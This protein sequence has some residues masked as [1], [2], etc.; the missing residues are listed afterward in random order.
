M[1]LAWIERAELL[2][3]AAAFICGIISATSLTVGQGEFG[4]QCILYGTASYNDTGKAFYISGF[5]SF[6]LCYFVSAISVLIAL[7]CFSI[8]LYWVYASCVDD[9]KRGSI[10]LNISLVVSSL[11]LFFL[12]VSACILRVGMDALCDSIL[13]TKQVESCP[14]AESEPWEAPADGSRF[15]ANLHNAEASAWANWVF[16]II[17]LVLLIIQ[18]RRESSSGSSTFRPLAAS[19]PEWATGETDAIFGSR[20]QRP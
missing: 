5:S 16:W 12:L 2:L 9:I 1:A 15:Y 19:D 3:Y 7:Y 11:V 6:S 20:P 14:Q 13:K 17:I 4:G 18:R 8:V 10:W